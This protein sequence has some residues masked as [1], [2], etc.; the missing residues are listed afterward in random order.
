M[1]NFKRAINKSQRHG[2]D[3]YEQLKPASSYSNFARENGL[4]EESAKGRGSWVVAGDSG[5][6]GYRREAVK[7][8]ASR[9]R[10]LR[11]RVPALWA[12]ATD[13]AAVLKENGKRQKE[14]KLGLRKG[15]LNRAR[16]ATA[17]LIRYMH[18]YRYTAPGEPQR[19]VPAWECSVPASRVLLLLPVPLPVL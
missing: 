7:G 2:D 14:K 1:W 13:P 10:K 6:T 9:T 12:R 19:A 15:H 3:Q 8:H 18:T 5:S 4:L 17:A 16:Y 11:R